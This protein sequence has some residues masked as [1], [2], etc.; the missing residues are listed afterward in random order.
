MASGEACS[1]E[2]LRWLQNTFKDVDAT[3]DDMIRHAAHVQK[4]VQNRFCNQLVALAEPL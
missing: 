1:G 3:I 4:P 2:M